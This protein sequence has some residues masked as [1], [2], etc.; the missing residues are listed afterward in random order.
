MS[1]FRVIFWLGAGLAALATLFAIALMP[2]VTLERPDDKLLKEKGK[3]LFG[4]KGVSKT[5]EQPLG[6]QND[7]DT[8][9]VTPK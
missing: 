4:A 9:V 2:Q 8:T 5:L 7:K 6:A 1:A 3:E